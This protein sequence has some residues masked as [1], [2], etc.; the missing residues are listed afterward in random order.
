MP[1]ALWK[2]GHGFQC[3]ASISSTQV[4][5]PFL[6]LASTQRPSSQYI[7][8]PHSPGALLGCA[9]TMLVA[10]AM[11]ASMSNVTN[12][13]FCCMFSSLAVRV[14]DMAGEKACECY[15][16]MK[17][18]QLHIG[19]KEVD[20]AAPCCIGTVH[21][22]IFTRRCGEVTQL[23]GDQ[24]LPSTAAISRSRIV[25]CLRSSRAMPG[26][27]SGSWSCAEP[28]HLPAFSSGR[29]RIAQLWFL[30]WLKY[31]VAVGGF[32]RGSADLGLECAT[33]CCRSAP[34]FSALACLPR[35][36]QVSA[37]WCDGPRGPHNE[38]PSRIVWCVGGV[39]L[40]WLVRMR[41]G[42]T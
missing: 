35:C 39:R 28:G 22:Q 40:A 3:L 32:H 31:A 27:N 19:L 26:R 25:M 24:P 9:A 1:A 12:H 42:V 34:P 23:R 18:D 13:F 38:L 11:P 7:F 5:S 10:A 30:R 37:A 4:F 33:T 29:A 21:S 20:S 36:C 41:S 14:D 6:S 16:F 8:S 15:D 17:N 2:E